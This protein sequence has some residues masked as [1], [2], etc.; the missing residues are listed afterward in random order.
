MSSSGQ[1]PTNFKNDQSKAKQPSFQIPPHN[2][3]SS[4]YEDDPSQ[5]A[6]AKYVMIQLENELF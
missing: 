4:D 6:I 1:Q 5:S 3:Y 2:P